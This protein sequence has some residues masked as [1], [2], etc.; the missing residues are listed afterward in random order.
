MFLSFSYHKK[1]WM[2]GFVALLWIAPL[3]ASDDSG[4]LTDSDTLNFD[5]EETYQGAGNILKTWTQCGSEQ[6]KSDARRRLIV[7]DQ[8]W[9]AARPGPRPPGENRFD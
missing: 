5:V 7:P 4:T 6:E 2:S 3:S 9:R 1:L 8:T